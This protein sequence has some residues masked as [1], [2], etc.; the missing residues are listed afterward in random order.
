[1]FDEEGKLI[2]T[3]GAVH[4]YMKITSVAKN[5]N[6]LAYELNISPSEILKHLMILRD[7]KKVTPVVDVQTEDWEKNVFNEKIK[8]MPVGDYKKKLKP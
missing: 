8:W 5:A 7:M 4:D 2:Q 6:Q 3:S 1:M